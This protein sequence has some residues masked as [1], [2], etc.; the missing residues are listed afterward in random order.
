M[1]NINFREN[2][3]VILCLLIALFLVLMPAET[4]HASWA[5]YIRGYFK[6]STGT[7]VQPYFRSSPNSTKID[8]YSTKGNTN[9]FTGSKGYTDPY[10]TYK[11]HSSPSYSTYKPYSDSTYTSPSYSSSFSDTYKP[12]SSSKYTSPSYNTYNSYLDY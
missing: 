3:F 8:N 7:Y 11:S 9:P 4:A 6:P 2:H 12:Y 10:T 5:S 1:K